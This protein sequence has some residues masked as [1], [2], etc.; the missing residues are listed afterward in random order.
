MEIQH[1]NI[2]LNPELYEAVELVLL[3]RGLYGPG[4]QRNRG[5]ESELEVVP[6]VSLA[7]RIHN[8]KAT[9][10]VPIQVAKRLFRWFWDSPENNIVDIIVKDRAFDQVDAY[11]EVSPDVKY[12]LEKALDIDPQVE[13]VR[14]SIEDRARQVRLRIAKVQFGVWYTQLDSTDPGKTFSVEHEREYLGQSSAYIKLI[15]KQSLICIDVSATFTGL[16]TTDNPTFQIRQQ[17]TE[18]INYLILVKFSSI[19][20]LGIGHDKSNQ[21]STLFRYRRFMFLIIDHN[22]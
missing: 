15:Y 9:L 6:G 5:Q 18:G 10:R 14:K 7:G 13:T 4:G 2:D 21:P 8:G 16:D 3:G 12:K 20:K 11:R 19:R 17:E 22:R 1:N